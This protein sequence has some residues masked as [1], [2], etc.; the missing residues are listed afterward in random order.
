M[1][2]TALNIITDAALSI[3]VIPP[4]GVLNPSEQS[5]GLIS[6]NKVLDS[7]EDMMLVQLSRV[8]VATGGGGPFTTPR[9]IKIKSATCTAGSLQSQVEV[10]SPESWATVS[11]ASR[12]GQLSSKLF[13]DYAYPTSNIYVW[14]ASTGVLHLFAY[15]PLTSFATL[16]TSID[17][18]PGYARALTFAVA[19]DMSPQYGHPIDAG[20]VG[21]VKDA[22]GEIQATNARLFRAAP[23]PA[24][25]LP[26][27]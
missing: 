14:P 6:L 15:L 13:C 7:W 11:D 21:M 3:N 25:P 16:A 8:T 20:I 24:Q 26:Q 9:P 18:P 17:L 19:L 5:D 12:S 10:C 1:T 4:G 23:P 22:K 27:R 2:I